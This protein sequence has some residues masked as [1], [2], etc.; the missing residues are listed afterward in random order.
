MK[1]KIAIFG[2]TG[3]IGTSTLEIIGNDL[4]KFSVEL[5]SAKDNYKKLISQA[6]KFKAKNVIIYNDKY[7][8][9][10]NKKLKKYKTKVFTDKTLLHRIIKKKIDCSVIS[11]VGIAGLKPTLDAIPVSD[12][13]IFANKESIVCGWQLIKKKILKYKTKLIPVDSEHFSIMKLVGQIP[14][15]EISEI[16]ITASGG[17]F[18]KLPTNK[19][20][21]VKP[22]Q[23]IKHPK[24]NMGSKISV[25]SANLMNKV[26]E[27]IEAYHLFNFKL[28]KYKIMIHP[29]SLVH[30]IIKFKNG[31]IKM[32]LHDTDMK[33]PISCALY[34]DH[35]N[36]KNIQKPLNE[37]QLSQLRFYKVD[38]K[39]FPAVNLI[40][41]Y[42]SKGKMAPTILNGANEELVKLFLRKKI[43]FTD[44]VKILGELVKVK[45]FDKFAKKNPKALRDIYI[46]D[47]WARLKTISIS[48][49]YFN[50]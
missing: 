31:L 39:K 29:Q 1:T 22:S 2:S 19:L 27:T 10:V 41:K 23:A 48:V 35:H 43:K 50:V 3:S 8:Y 16:V 28:K 13:L 20:K 45:G 37:K 32:L 7:F 38:K 5:L 26:F 25:D 46:C 12:K 34:D 11:I 33:I 49:R 9:Y 40:K 44:I 6:I 18:L 30:G 42:L 17:P 21:S 24:W 47:S 15:K 36:K 14:D 4:N